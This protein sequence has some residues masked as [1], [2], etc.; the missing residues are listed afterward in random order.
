MQEAV[1]IRPTLSAYRQR[2]MPYGHR[3]KLSL[4]NCDEQ[5]VFIYNE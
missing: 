4:V 1:M 5:H 3:S 2:L